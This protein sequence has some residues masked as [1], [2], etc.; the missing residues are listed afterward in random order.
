MGSSPRLR[1]L[2]LVTA[3]AAL[4]QIGAPAL[5][6]PGTSLQVNGRS[7]AA[8]VMAPMSAKIRWDTSAAVDANGVFLFVEA[9]Q[10]AAQSRA[11]ACATGGDE[12]FQNVSGAAGTGFHAG[13]QETLSQRLGAGTYFV[14]ACAA[15]RRSD[16]GLVNR[17]GPTN[18]VQLTVSDKRPS[19]GGGAD[20]A[21][22]PSKALPDLIPVALAVEGHVKAHDDS[23]FHVFG[24]GVGL[25][26][27]FDESGGTFFCDTARVLVYNAGATASTRTDV[28]VQ[29]SVDEGG[30]RHDIANTASLDGIKPRRCREVRV[31]LKNTKC[32]SP[33]AIVDRKGAVAEL[34]ES[35]NA[36]P[37]VPSIKTPCRLRRSGP[38]HKDH[39]TGTTRDH[40]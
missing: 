2:T 16:G 1:A 22:D 33:S 6:G 7:D 26:G 35:N 25:A 14:F 24:Y 10:G 39:R 19:T 9:S 17:H 37:P 4:L 38:K 3:S 29:V 8:N 5:A 27:S 34:S 28:R 21:L 40:R 15:E 11:G 18:I 36:I 30:P 31:P 23:L 20:T 13:N 32:S 12:V